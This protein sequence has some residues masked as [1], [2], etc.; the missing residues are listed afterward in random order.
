[1]GGFEKNSPEVHEEGPPPAHLRPCPLRSSPAPAGPLPAA[2]PCACWATTPGPGRKWCPLV[3]AEAYLTVSLFS[4]SRTLL[5]EPQQVA[6]GGPRTPLPH[7]HPR[8]TPPVPRLDGTPLAPPRRLG[9]PSPRRHMRGGR[10]RRHC[11]RVGRAQRVVP[12]SHRQGECLVVPAQ[13]QDEAY[14]VV[15]TFVSLEPPYIES[16]V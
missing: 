13:T 2:S 6:R 15:S 11:R 5:T 4:L 7:S 8:R 14:R 1:M 3:H 12:T 10:R 9:R 16:T